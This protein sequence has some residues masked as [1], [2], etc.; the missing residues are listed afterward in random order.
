MFFIEFTDYL[1]IMKRFAT[2]ISPDKGKMLKYIP[3]NINLIKVFRANPGLLAAVL[4]KKWNSNIPGFTR[5]LTEALFDNADYVKHLNIIYVDNRKIFGSNTDSPMVTNSHQ[6]SPMVTN[7]GWNWHMYL[8]LV[9][10]RE[11]D[12]IN[13][14]ARKWGQDIVDLFNNT[15]V[16]TKFTRIEYFEFGEIVDSEKSVCSI[17]LYIVQNSVVKFCIQEYFVSIEDGTFFEDKSLMDE[18]FPGVKEPKSLFPYILLND[19]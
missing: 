19:N 6:W 18:L 7:G 4:A 12:S 10:E 9:Q 2:K 5:Y 15:I 17:S 13:D 14:V 8:R 3:G 1:I 11:L 16:P